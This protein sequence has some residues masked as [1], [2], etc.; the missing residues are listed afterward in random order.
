M[1]PAEIH[2]VIEQSIFA[3]TH[4]EAETFASL[5]TDDGEFIVPGNRWVGPLAIRKALAD[6][7]AA[8]SDVSIQLLQVMIATPSSPEGDRV[9]LEWHWENTDLKTRERIVADDA[10]AIDFRGSKISRWR[11]YIDSQSYKQSTHK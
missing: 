3:W 10:I 8:A 11:E 1:R 6:F 5:F 2:A 9:L 7:A 4:G